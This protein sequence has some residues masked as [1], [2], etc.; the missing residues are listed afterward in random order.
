MN[1]AKRF[2]LAGAAITLV[3]VL[4]LAA[5]LT[6][7]TPVQA[8]SGSTDGICGRTEQVRYAIFSKLGRDPETASCA[9]VTDTDLSGIS[10]ELRV[11]QN[12]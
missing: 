5:A 9:N 4:A 1:S 3:V 2:S 10:G 8:N 6:S 11:W 7:N 12:P